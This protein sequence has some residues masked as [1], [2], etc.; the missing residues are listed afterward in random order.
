MHILIYLL[1]LIATKAISE[2][3]NEELKT[4]D[5]GVYSFFSLSTCVYDLLTP[6]RFINHLPA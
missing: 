4:S 2:I 3:E 5:I 1:N 6:L